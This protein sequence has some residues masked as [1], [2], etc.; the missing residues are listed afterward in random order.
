MELIT[1][2]P[3]HGSATDFQKDDNRIWLSHLF[4]MAC[5]KAGQENSAP[6]TKGMVLVSTSL[7][8]FEGDQFKAQKINITEKQVCVEWSLAESPHVLQSTWAFCHETG[9][10]SRKDRFINRSDKPMT[11]FRCLARYVFAP[12]RYEIYLQES[13]WSFENQGFWEPLRAGTRVLG[14]EWGRTT[15]NGTPYVCLRE[16]TTN[17]GVAFHIIPRGNWIIRVRADHAGARDLPYAVVELGLADEDLRLRLA[18]GTELDLP[19]ILVQQ[20]PAGEPERAAPGLHRYL[21]RRI[22]SA[23]KPHLPVVYNT[24]FDQFST[25]EVQ[26][27]RDQL[28]VVKEIGCEVFVIDA[29]WFGVGG[30][31][32][33][34]LGDWREDTSR[35]FCGHMLEFADEVRAAGLGFGLW[36]EPERSDCNAP[37]YR[38][39]PEWFCDYHLKLENPAASAWLV[40]EF[41]RLIETYQLAWV[42]IDMNM[43]SGYDP[44]GAELY[45]YH[46]AWCRLL[47]EIRRR[48]P[49]TVIENCASGGLRQDIAACFHYDC[50]FISDTVNPIDVLRISQGAWL[51]LPPGR[52]ARWLVLRS[53]G[54][55]IPH[56]DKPVADSDHSVVTPGGATWIRSEKIP[57]DFAAQAALPGA[58]GLSGDFTNFTPAEIKRLRWYVDFNKQWR[59][60]LTNAT[61]YLLTRPAGL[62]D[63]EG[64][65]GFQMQSSDE[66]TSV[67]FFYHLSDGCVRKRFPLC[68]L[69]PEIKYL[70]RRESPEGNSEQSV[71]GQVLMQT[72]LDVEL[73]G[74][75]HA[76]PLACIYIVRPAKA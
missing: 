56:F 18:P 29:G 46:A 61:G 15:H 63:R 3:D 42:K 31:G 64:W 17:H 4:G 40:G 23:V 30:K 54:R 28:R 39:H 16:Q 43:P 49:A 50:H 9:I 34:I 10:W 38:E 53:V 25:L 26:R 59:A 47:D 33:G 22:Q 20:L 76:Q 19:E 35:A 55:T 6:R 2:T 5:G 65:L 51:R 45:C 12:G 37:V 74:G 41:A 13:R 48:Y 1:F 8:R 57:L 58:L 36:L 44:T 27:L 68:N 67:L 70:V 32:W 7:G 21:N 62:E 73:D 14:C 24:W 71:M 60:L 11:L 75:F 66:S 72:G 69:N 52:L